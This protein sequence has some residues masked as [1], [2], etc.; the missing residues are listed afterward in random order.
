MYRV[1]KKKKK[2][3]GVKKGSK[4]GCPSDCREEWVLRRYLVTNVAPRGFM[5]HCFDNW[6]PVWYKMVNVPSHCECPR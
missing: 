2:L 6:L 1:G 4:N 3:L 5:G